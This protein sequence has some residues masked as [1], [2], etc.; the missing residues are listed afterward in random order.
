MLRFNSV[1]I[2]LL[3]T[4][5]LNFLLETAKCSNIN[6]TYCIIYRGSL[7]ANIF[8]KSIYVFWP[9]K[10]QH[11]E[12]NWIPSFHQYKNVFE[13]SRS[14]YWHKYVVSVKGSSFIFDVF[15]YQKRR[16]NFQE[17]IQVTQSVKDQFK[18][19]KSSSSSSYVGIILPKSEI[20]IANEKYGWTW[21][22]QLCLLFLQYRYFQK[23]SFFLV[24][25]K[26]NSHIS[27]K[28]KMVTIFLHEETLEKQ[29]SKICMCIMCRQVE[30]KT[31]P[32]QKNEVTNSVETSRQFSPLLQKSYATRS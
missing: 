9:R 12:V 18:M 5:Y 13:C 14:L 7:I 29:I 19:L 22:V 31:S 21:S 11:S 1:L 23:R 26:E 3:F 32:F 16:F 6:V 2:K 25:L 27:W 30:W 8:K 4:R 24:S 10:Y 20:S 28:N 17:L 15:L